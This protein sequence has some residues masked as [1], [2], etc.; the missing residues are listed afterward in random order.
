MSGLEGQVALV[1]GGGSGVGAAIAV[2]LAV[3]KVDVWILGRTSG[4]LR[5]TAARAHHLGGRVECIVFDLG[6]AGNIGALSDRLARDL[7][8]LDILAQSAA[9]YVAGTVSQTSAE[10][11]DQLYS[12]NVRA[13]YLL[14]RALLPLLR[15]SQGQIVLMNSSGGV[16]ARPGTSQYDATKHALKALADGLRGEV[17]SWGIRV[18]SLYLGRTATKLQQQ[19]HLAENKVY[20][21]ELLLQSEDVASVILHALCLPRT[22]EITDLHIRP[23]I[24]PARQ[25]RH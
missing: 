15:E 4:P 1:T 22:A 21:P 16:A 23:M 2:A 17:N 24:D 25:D 19:I 11:L 14:T 12:V 3:A 10:V 18:L 8:R 5:E 7:P 6:D 13:P 9:L 20:R